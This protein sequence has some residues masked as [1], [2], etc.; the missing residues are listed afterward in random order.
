MIF[1]SMAGRSDVRALQ[2]TAAA[3]VLSL[4][5]CAANE[6][7]TDAIDAELTRLE[8]EAGLLEDSKAI[9]RLQRSYGYYVDKGMGD[10]IGELFS[11]RP[12]ASVEIAGSGVYVGKDRVSEFYAGAAGSL[13][14]G[15]L[16]NHMILQ[17]VVHVAS[18]GMTAMGRWR[19]HLRERIR[20]G[21]RYLE[22]RLPARLPDLL[23]A[24]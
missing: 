5:G 4:A 13:M 3:V 19:G 17:G 2:M 21:G 20:Q 8:H 10:R 11:D 9:K 6:T 16:N 7:S 14:E 24:I 23:H 15:Q 12:D 18:G 1:R 22:D